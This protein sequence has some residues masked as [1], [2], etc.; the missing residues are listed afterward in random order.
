MD[1]KD[2][3][4][5]KAYLKNIPSPFSK[6]KVLH[7]NAPHYINQETRRTCLIEKNIEDGLFTGVSYQM[8]W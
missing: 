3:K 8:L 2:F 6:K 7:A 1:K 4:G 5:C